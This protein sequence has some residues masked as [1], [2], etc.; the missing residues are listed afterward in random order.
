MNS[1]DN[2]KEMMLPHIRRLKPY[3]GVDPME[4]IAE[5]AGIPADQVI[6]LNGNE[7][8]FGPSPVV[9]EALGKFQF[10]NHY[11]DPEQRKL[12]SVLSKYLGAPAERIVAGNGSDELIDLLLRMFLGPGEN[13]I[14]PSPTFGMYSFTADI[15][16]GEAIAIPSDENF[17]IDV[18]AMVTAMTSKTK[19][20]FL[21]SPNNPS[22]NIASVSQIR[23]LLETGRL[24]VV[25][26]TYYEFCGESVMPLMEEYPNLV[27]LRTFSKWAGLAG[28]RIGLGVMQEELA[29]TMISM[30]PPYNV[31]TAAEVALTASL[32]DTTVLLDRVKSIVAERE[33]MMGLLQKIP[34]IKAWP[35]QANFILFS[36]PEGQGERIFE[37]LCSRGIFLR[38]FDT[39][40]LKDYIRS[41]VGFPHETDA[42]VAALTELVGAA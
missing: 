33:R 10:Y 8:P 30:K 4:V 17:E 37:G 6:R 21:A 24:I 31:N 28:L 15:C 23:A 36:L 22:G 40:Q 7:N 2:L 19:A 27:I 16:G 12:R 42:V 14:I 29:Q 25:D 5:R 35:S 32:E 26:E 34:G 11:T 38:Y 13:I 9:N 41:S 18:E 39:P 3:Q 1:I 20:V